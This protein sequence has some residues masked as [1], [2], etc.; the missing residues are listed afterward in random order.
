MNRNLNAACH[1]RASWDN[2]RRVIVLPSTKKEKNQLRLRSIEH[3]RRVCDGI[4]R[5]NGE[6]ASLRFDMRYDMRLMND[7]CLRYLCES[8]V[9]VRAV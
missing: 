8:G 6:M 3:V 1:T 7:E 2:D 4:M 9:R 5:E